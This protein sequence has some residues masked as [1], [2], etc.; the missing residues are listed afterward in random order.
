MTQSIVGGGK[1]KKAG[2]A[3]LFSLPPFSKTRPVIPNE[4]RNPL[5]I[6]HIHYDE[7]HSINETYFLAIIT[8]IKLKQFT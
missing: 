8:Q 3:R 7:S 1:E 6:R 4:V 5:L 2:F